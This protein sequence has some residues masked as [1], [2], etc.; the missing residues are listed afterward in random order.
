MYALLYDN[1]NFDLG[2]LDDWFKAN[3]LSLNVNKTKFMVFPSLPNDLQICVGNNP[4]DRVDTFKF[5]G[6]KIDSKLNWHDHI[7]FVKSKL[8]SAHYAINSVEH[9]LPR[10]HFRMLNNSI[11]KSHIEYGLLLWGNTHKSYT[12]QIVVLQKKCIRAIMGVPYNAHSEPLFQHLKLM[13]FEQLLKYHLGKF[14]YLSINKQL[15]INLDIFTRNNVLHDHQTRQRNE[16]HHFIRRTSLASRCIT[17]T[18]PSY[19]HSLPLTMKNS[20][21]IVQFNSSHRKY[22]TISER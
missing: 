20:L 12:N 18:G 8:A 22:L 15:P 1:M 6:L 7:K 3:K 14:M 17:F 21:N 10:L 5:L 13:N 11:V 4:V 16:P 9:F 19:W 2:I